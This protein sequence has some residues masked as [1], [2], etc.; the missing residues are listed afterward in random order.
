MRSSRLVRDEHIT[1]RGA[2]CFACGS[3]WPIAHWSEE[4]SVL[5]K[6]RNFSASFLSPSSVLVTVEILWMRKRVRAKI[7]KISGY[8]QDEEGS[9]QALGNRSDRWVGMSKMR[10]RLSFKATGPVL[11]ELPWTLRRVAIPN[12]PKHDATGDENQAFRRFTSASLSRRS[13]RSR[14]GMVCRW[15]VSRRFLMLSSLSSTRPDVCPR[16]SNRFVI[17]SSLART[18]RTRVHGAI[19]GRIRIDSIGNVKGKANEPFLRISSPEE[20]P[21]DNRRWEIP[22]N[23][24]LWRA[25]SLWVDRA[26]LPEKTKDEAFLLEQRMSVDTIGTS[27]PSFI[28]A[29]N[30]SPR[31]LFDW[32]VSRRRSLRHVRWKR[33]VLFLSATLPGAQ[34]SVAVFLNDSFA[35]R[36]FAGAC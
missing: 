32:T 26:P 2:F 3:S 1:T 36:T 16:W 31:S 20:L 8:K 19:Y 4:C 12:W 14:T 10:A 25:Y 27:F 21:E 24:Q 33:F 22:S 9:S 29:F 18:Y 11:P 30:C 35:L 5:E 34:M 23:D 7:M 17:V 6:K 28:K 13:Y 15:N